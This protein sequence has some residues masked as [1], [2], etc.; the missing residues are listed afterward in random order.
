MCDADE[1]CQ[2]GEDEEEGCDYNCDGDKLMCDNATCI[3]ASWKCDGHSDCVDQSDEENC[4]QHSCYENEF[5][6][7]GNNKGQCI[8]HSWVCDGDKDC[9]NG[10][11]EL[12]G[13]AGCGEYTVTGLH[14]LSWSVCHCVCA[15]ACRACAMH[16]Q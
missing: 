5:S 14:V 15:S 13:E 8:P 7:D 3:P 1:D 11:D 16:G 9:H 2:F 6:C 12:R 4:E 10:R